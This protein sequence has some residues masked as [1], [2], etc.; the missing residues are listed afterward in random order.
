MATNKIDSGES[1]RYTA[2]ATHGSGE[3]LDL[4]QLVGIAQEDMVSGDEA[5]LLLEG[6]FNVPCASDL[7]FAQFA[8]A[9]HDGTTGVNATT[10]GTFAGTVRKAVAATTILV[11]IKINAL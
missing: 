7:S 10:T 5:T 2:G 6:V 1:V 4:G 8:L 9:Y 3:L 11:P